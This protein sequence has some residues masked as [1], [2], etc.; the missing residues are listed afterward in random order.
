MIYQY[1]CRKCDHLFER[2]LKMSERLKPT[3]EP[4]PE[5]G[6]TGQVYQSIGATPMGDP[7]RMGLIKP[8]SGFNQVLK[9]IKKGN[10]GS[11]VKIRD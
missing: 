3:M 9:N 11:T 4:C 2:V 10:P 7:H 6:E 5:C 1:R 8:D